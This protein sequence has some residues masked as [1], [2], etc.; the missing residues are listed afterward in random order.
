MISLLCWYFCKYAIKF[1]IKRLDR[2]QHNPNCAVCIKYK[3]W[4]KNKTV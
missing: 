2:H 3:E 4:C 1:S